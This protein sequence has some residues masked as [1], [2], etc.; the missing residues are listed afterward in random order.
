MRLQNS[1]RKMQGNAHTIIHAHKRLYI[2]PAAQSITNVSR[3]HT[4][5][6][7]HLATELIHTYIQTYICTHH[8]RPLLGMLRFQ[9]PTQ[10][11][12]A[13]C[14]VGLRRRLSDRRKTPWPICICTSWVGRQSCRFQT[15]AA[16]R[17]AALA[18]RLP[19]E[20]G[21]R[22]STK[23]MFAANSHAEHAAP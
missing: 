21:G 4:C 15:C 12:V 11:Q 22:A 16:L 6:A 13:F 23:H 2:Q 3:N 19:A 17:C 9:T 18:A 20:R 14:L 7:D 10:T 1:T 8:A 5:T